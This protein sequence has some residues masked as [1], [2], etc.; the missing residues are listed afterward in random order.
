MLGLDLWCR[1]LHDALLIQVCRG[2]LSFEKLI[3]TENRLLWSIKQISLTSEEKDEYAVER[4]TKAISEDLISTDNMEEVCRMIFFDYGSYF[5]AQHWLAGARVRRIYERRNRFHDLRI[6]L[7]TAVVNLAPN[8]SNSYNNMFNGSFLGR[9]WLID[10]CTHLRFSRDEIDE[11]MEATHNSMLGKKEDFSEPFS[12]FKDKTLL[13]RL[14]IMLLESLYLYMLDKT[15]SVPPVDYMLDPFRT[16]YESGRSVMRQLD[17]F[18]DSYTADPDNMEDA[19]ADDLS[20]QD[21]SETWMDVVERVRGEEAFSPEIWDLYVSE[22]P[23]YYE[24]RAEQTAAMDTIPRKVR[25]LHLFAA[26]SFTVLTGRQYS[27][28]Y[29]DADLDEIRLLFNSGKEETKGL[30][31]NIY[32]FISQIL[33]TFLGTSQIYEDEGGQYRIINPMTGQ[34]SRRGLDLETI[35]ENLWESI[36]FIK[37]EEPAAQK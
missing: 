15:A 30:F 35:T 33:A 16:S 24:L 7:K 8:Y 31:N 10:L 34:K 17:R 37:E 6:P 11:V 12:Y 29:T 4:K 23:A 1:N 18:L 27:G 20:A 21:F 2:L 32:M 25:L 5:A 9:E 36:V 26:V 14:K 22:T 28:K 3:D 13:E 19:E